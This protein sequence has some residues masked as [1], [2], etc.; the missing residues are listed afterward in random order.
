MAFEPAT[1][2]VQQVAGEPS[3]PQAH[4][5]AIWTNED[6]AEH[7]VTFDDSRVVSSGRIATGQRFEAVLTLPGTFTY[8]CVIH[9]SMSGAVEVANAPATPVTPGSGE[10]SATGDGDEG[11]G[12]LVTL[13]LVGA[14]LAVAAVVALLLL[15]RRADGTSED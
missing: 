7:T 11:S 6:E 2:Q 4:G 5:H 12:G 9:P 10:G 8:R 1:V 3:F 13:V 15:R 14:G